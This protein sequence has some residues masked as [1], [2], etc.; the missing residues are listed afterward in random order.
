M[1]GHKYVKHMFVMLIRPRWYATNDSDV[2]FANESL[3]WI[4]SFKLFGRIDF[5][6]ASLSYYAYNPRYSKINV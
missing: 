2:R 1:T 3:K 5:E 4:D 6:V